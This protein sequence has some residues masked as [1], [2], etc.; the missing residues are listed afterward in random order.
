MKCELIFFFNRFDD[1]NQCIQDMA[2]TMDR[3]ILYVA[4]G[5]DISVL[6]I[7]R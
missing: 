7:S 5:N 4:R 3:N 1:N 6:D 2:T